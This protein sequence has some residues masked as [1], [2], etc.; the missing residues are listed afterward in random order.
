MSEIRGLTSIQ[1]RGAVLSVLIV[2]VIAFLLNA[3]KIVQSEGRPENGTINYAEQD[4]NA[5][6]A[7]W[8]ASDIKDYEISVEFL[9]GMNV[10]E[11]T[12]E[13]REHGKEIVLLRG[14]DSRGPDGEID[15]T[16]YNGFRSFTVDGLFDWARDNLTEPLSSGDVDRDQ[17]A[18]FYDYSA[19]F[20]GTAG[21][22]T[23]IERKG[24]APRRWREGDTFVMTSGPSHSSYF[25]RVVGFRVLR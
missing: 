23:Q 4:I 5:G 1:I 21:F 13:V 24:R 9:L 12:L 10:G 11:L 22:P 7:K 20:D 19:T 3:D 25:V 15:P 14:E 18:F 6:L 17:T 8:R 16:D 2:M